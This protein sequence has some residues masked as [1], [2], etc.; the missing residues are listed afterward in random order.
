MRLGNV[1][2]TRH[3]GESTEEHQREDHESL[4]LNH[5][6]LSLLTRAARHCPG[7][8]GIELGQEGARCVSTKAPT[9]RECI[10]GQNSTTAGLTGWI[11]RRAHRISRRGDEPTAGGVPRHHRNGRLGQ[12][13][14]PS[15]PRRRTGP[16][17]V[18]IR[19]IFCWCARGDLNSHGLPHWILS[20]RCADHAKANAAKGQQRL[21][22]SSRRVSR[23]FNWS[24]RRGARRVR[25]AA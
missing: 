20:L 6:P 8:N 16:S 22:H 3:R 14:G 7:A 11:A 10:A 2:H 9:S 5:L 23:L 15:R 24:S 19:E 13:L 17:G 4:H 1:H 21:S 18:C 12:L 25:L